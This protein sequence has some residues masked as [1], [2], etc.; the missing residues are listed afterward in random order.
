MALTTSTITGRVPLP[1]DEVLQYAE[2]TFA[3]SGLDTQGADVLPGG[4]IKRVTLVN[5]ELPPGFQLWCNTAGLRGTHYCV[6]ARWSV[7]DRDGIRDQYADLGII[8]VGSSP[9]YT[10]ASLINS[11]VP[12]AIGTFWSSIT[13]AQYDAAIAAQEA[14]ELAADQA[15]LYEGP[16]F[17]NLAALV[18]DTTLTYTAGQPSTVASGDYVQTRADRSSYR[19]ASSGATNHHVTTAGGVRL[20]ESGLNYTTVARFQQAV[21]RNDLTGIASGTAVLAGGQVFIAKSGATE[22]PLLPGFLAFSDQMGALSGNFAD[23]NITKSTKLPMIRLQNGAVGGGASTTRIQGVDYDPIARQ[24]FTIHSLSGSPEQTVIS[25]L[26]TDGSR[27]SV[28]DTITTLGHGQDIGVFYRADG[29]RWLVSQTT[30]KLNATFFQYLA[31]AGP[32]NAFVATLF[33]DSTYTTININR[34]KTRLIALGEPSDVFKVRF[35]DLASI[36]A[37]GDYSSS[38]IHEVEIEQAP[39]TVATN[40]VQSVTADDKL[41]YIVSGNAQTTEPKFLSAYDIATGRLI[42]R[43]EIT[44]RRD[45]ALAQN[46]GAGTEYEPEGMTWWSSGAGEKVLVCGFSMDQPTTSSGAYNYAILLRPG[47]WAA[48]IIN[49]DD[50]PTDIGALFEGGAGDIGWVEGAVLN[51]VSVDNTLPAPVVTERGRVTTNVFTWLSA[52]AATC[53]KTWTGT[54]ADDNAATIPVPPGGSGSA[55]MLIVC[56]LNGV[57]HASGILK[58]RTGISASCIPLIMQDAAGALAAPADVTLT[59]G[60]ILGGTTGTDNKTT[61]SVHSNGNVYLENR[62]GSSAIYTVMFVSAG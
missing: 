59:T 20:Y 27:I 57:R 5:S 34:D 11:S 53:F 46:S 51:F 22:F 3:L 61:I 41:I 32:Q 18:A 6:L 52:I 30:N 36:T 29:S 26:N 43:S 42:I 45:F 16:W 28:S 4:I 58:I 62:S 48:L 1:T 24:W 13:Q 40:A 60:T 37:S 10:L 39:F 56:S 55:L 49:G 25:L 14:A 47:R 7:K 9:S 21:A 23:P 38:Y 35:W 15:A 50:S 31:G 44:A 19:V 8:Q 33:T 2:L 12:S 54:L 17:N